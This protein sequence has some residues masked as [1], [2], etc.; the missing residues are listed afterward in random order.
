NKANFVSCSQQTYV[1]KYDVL[2]G[3]KD[4]GTFLLNTIWDAAELEQNLP[5]SMKRTLAQKHIQFYTI[6]AVKIAQDIGLGG[7]FNMIMQ[8]A[9][10][11]LADIIPVEDAVKYLKDAV[12]TNY[13]KKGQKVVDM[14]NAAIDQGVSQIVKIDIPAAWADATDA[15]EAQKDVPEFITKLQKPINAQEGDS[16]PVSAFLG[17]EDGAFPQGT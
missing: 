8:S 5:A 1:H 9:F 14:N 6:N 16:L 2:A 12:V 11:K 17:L 3:I 10:F 4:G 15:P 7:R 13:G